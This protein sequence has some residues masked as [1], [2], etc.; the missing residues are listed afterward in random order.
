MKVQVKATHVGTNASDTTV[1]SAALSVTTPADQ[2]KIRIKKDGQ[3]V[4]GK[5]YFKKNGQWVKAKKIYIKKN[6]NWV[7]GNNYDPE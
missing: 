3:W 5:T 2:A 1:T 6:G 4:K 7:I